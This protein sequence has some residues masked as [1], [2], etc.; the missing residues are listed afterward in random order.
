VRPVHL[1]D[2]FF[3]AL[4]PGPP[5]AADEAWI[6]AVLPADELLLLRR[7][8]NHDRRHAIRVARTV[9]AR[10]GPAADPRWVRAALL[11]DVGKY[12][13]GLSVVGRALATVAAGVGGPAR[14]ERWAGRRGWRGRVA[15]YAQHGEIGA[16]EI[17]AVGGDEAAA[18]WSAAHHHPETWARLPIPPDVVAVLDAAD[19]AL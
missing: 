5:R 16:R 12:D 1:V 15:A 2:R 7:L 17:R 13:A 14:V 3:R 9:E 19:Y 4:W 11:H 10:L 18:A 6:D 8:P